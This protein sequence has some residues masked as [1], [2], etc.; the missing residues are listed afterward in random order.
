MKNNLLLTIALSCTV[1]LANAQMRV[2]GN[3][4]VTLQSTD[5]VGSLRVSGGIDGM[6]IGD[7]AEPAIAMTPKRPMTNCPRS[8]PCLSTSLCRQARQNPCRSALSRHRVFQNCITPCRPSSLGQSIRTWCM[9]GKT[10]FYQL[11]AWVGLS[12]QM[13]LPAEEHCWAV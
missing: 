1:A 6:V 9:S 5:V 8:P 12:R 11:L 13:C 3:G 2:S 7:G 10:L 4:N